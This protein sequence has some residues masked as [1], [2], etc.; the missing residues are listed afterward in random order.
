MK[1]CLLAKRIGFL[2]IIGISVFSP[3]V[4]MAQRPLKIS[5][6][7]TE[8]CSAEVSFP[9][10]YGDAPNAPGAIIL[11][12]RRDG[13]TDWSGVF[14]RGLDGSHHLRW[15]CHSTTG[16]WAD[17]GTWQLHDSSFACSATGTANSSG[18]YDIKPSCDTPSVHIRT[19]DANGWTAERSRCNSRT[20]YFRAR[21]GP[22]RLLEIQCI[23]P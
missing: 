16:N 3:S 14:K 18:G 8:R 2:A 6:T 22:R 13:W 11:V 19:I 12:R 15:Y 1:F 9:R 4:L 7:M 23:Q 21:L 20:D 10:L 5:E 17:P